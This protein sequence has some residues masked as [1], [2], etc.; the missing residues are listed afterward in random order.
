MISEKS[1]DLELLRH[2]RPEKKDFTAQYFD[3]YD[4]IANFMRPKFFDW[5]A[6]PNWYN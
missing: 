1:H 5:I 6:N 2:Y 4:D 3:N